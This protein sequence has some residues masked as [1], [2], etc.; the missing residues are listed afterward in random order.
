MSLSSSA[1]L[2]GCASRL[3]SSSS[4]PSFSRYSLAFRQVVQVGFSR[5]LIF[6]FAMNQ[7]FSRAVGTEFSLCASIPRHTCINFRRPAFDAARH[8]LCA[9]DALLP[10]PHLGV[11]AAHPVMAI[12]NDVACVQQR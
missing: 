2:S 12:A 9:L 3:R 10:E 6:V 7:S 1:S 4:A 5:N 8:R 11:E